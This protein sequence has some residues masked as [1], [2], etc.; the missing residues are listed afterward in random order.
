MWQ[1][2]ENQRGTWRDF[3]SI[4]NAEVEQT[5]QNSRPGVVYLWPPFGGPVQTEYSIDFSAMQ[6]TNKATDFRRRVRRVIIVGVEEAEHMEVI[7]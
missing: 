1:V 2:D 5:Y 7:K 3:P 4:L 6:Q